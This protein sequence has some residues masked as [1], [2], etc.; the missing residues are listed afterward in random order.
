MILFPFI[1]ETAD[2][3]L[4][5]A[6]VHLK[7]ARLT[8]SDECNATAAPLVKNSSMDALIPP[9]DD[10]DALVTYYIDHLEQLHRVVHVSTFKRQYANFW[11]RGQPR[12]PTTVALI[13]SMIAISACASGSSGDPTSV[14]A[15][16]RDAPS[17]WILSC[18]QW[19]RQQSPKY[20]KPALY[21][22]SC[23]VYLAKRMNMVHKKRF[24]TETGV[25]VQ[26]AIID[27][28]HCDTSS[29]TDSP[30][31]IEMRRRIWHV[32]RKLELQNSYEYGLP[33]LL[34]NID[35]TVAAPAN[36][37]DEEFDEASAVIR[38][39]KPAVH[40]TRTSYQSLSACSWALRLEVSR[41]LFSP[42]FSQPL[43]YDDVLHYTH[44]ITQATA[45]LPAWDSN[46][47]ANDHH[48]PRQLP[49]LASA[50]LQFQLKECV[51]ALHRP[52]LQR[53][54]SKFWLSENICHHMSRDMLL[55]NR[56]LVEFGVQSLANLR[57]DLLLASLNLTRITMMQPPRKF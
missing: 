55:L 56:Q 54:D 27:G 46:P 50:F 18:E 39:S 44:D 47:V 26:G 4:K 6:G 37:D 8:T 33:T 32:I 14:G 52:Y 51:L 35:S 40:Y 5:P 48:G 3:W 49:V 42:A 15:R 24:W 17:S 23:L 21:Q 41:R 38:S 43:T 22:I 45:D 11:I 36:I 10:A 2:E 1:I 7:K 30:F 29:T 9:K 12:S 28:L 25:L 16:Y 19:L 34:H 57:E 13:L 31:T 53:G 20:H